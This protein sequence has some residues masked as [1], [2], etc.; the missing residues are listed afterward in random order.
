MKISAVEILNIV[1]PFRLTFKHSLAIRSEVESILVRVF[2]GAG[3]VGY[4]ECAPR[5][6]VT[7]ES[8]STVQ[9]VLSTT[10]VPPYL[11][12][13]FSSF[14]EVTVALQSGLNSLPRHHHAAFCALELALLDLAGKVFGL[15]AGTVAGPVLHPEICYSGIVSADGVE[16]ALKTCEGIRRFGFRSVKMKVGANPESDLRILQGARQILGESCSLRIDANGAWSAE[17]ALRQLEAFKPIRLDGVEQPLPQ[18][19]L[20][21]LAWLA[22]RSPVPVIVDESLVSRD[23]AQRLAERK[24]CHCFN[25][26][27]SKCGGLLNALKIRDIGE[28]AGIQCMLGA[29]VGETA[30]LSAAGRH[31]G[32]RTPKALFFEGSYGT[33]LLERDIGVEDLTVH[34]GGRAPALEKPGLGVNVDESVVAS[35]VEQSVLLGEEPCRSLPN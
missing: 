23:D 8:P 13:T 18:A 29:H 33:L 16:E 31:F 14:Q 21:G 12:V 1:I 27:I 24:A 10:M 17:Q 11:G 7:G 34:P 9:E 20:D 28:R 35:F 30:L 15:S 3:H 4:G 5:D 2:D 22:E 25:I 19:E 32:T 6:Y 26:R